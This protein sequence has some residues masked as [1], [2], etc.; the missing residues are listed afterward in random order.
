MHEQKLK[1]ERIKSNLERYVSA[2]VVEAILEEKDDFSF[3]PAKRDIAILFS[4]IRNFSTKCEELPPELIVE[5][6]N[7]YFTHCCLEL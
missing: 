5:Y 6:L 4:D 3:E 1:E 2:K 7:E